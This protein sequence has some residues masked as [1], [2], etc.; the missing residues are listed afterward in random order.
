MVHM[1]TGVDKLVG[2]VARDKKVDINIAAKELN[3]DPAV[4][5]EWAEFL[6]EEGI[7]S[8][9][10][11]LSKTFILEK[12]LSKTEVVK[13]NKEYDNKKE[14]FVR[15]VEFALKKLEDE[16][17]GFES[18]KKQYD[19]MKHHIGDEID[20]VREEMEQLH[21]YEE[22][23]KNI[24]SD[25]LKQKVEYQKTLD[26]VHQRI[27]QEERRYKKIVEEVS[28]EA[29]KIEQERS[30]FLD[31]KKEEHDLLK[32]IEALKDIVK[33]VQ[34]RVETHESV[35]SNHE[36]RLGTLRELADKLRSDI[37]EK[38]KKEIEPLLKISDDQSGRI[39]RIQNE[40]VEKV[41]AGRDKMQEFEKQSREISER[42]ESFFK[43]R[44]QTEQV[45][46][47]L[48]KAKLEM[49]EELSAL[50]R[51]AKAFEITDK[52]ADT[53]THVRELEKKF[54]DFDKK[55]N[56]FARQLDYLKEVILGKNVKLPPRIPEA[57][58][59]AVRAKPKKKKKR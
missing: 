7:V 26:E 47:D 50:I 59:P 31:L 28:D 24:D 35:L 15:R 58:K 36:Q 40:I 20:A 25:I 23:K 4:V 8:L 42:F 14:A 44:S 56:G 51:K 57:K 9:Q 10:F 49:K 37:I 11:S 18:I 1:E 46:Q 48:E 16:T 41:K 29:H 45:M 2:I 3:V 34:T 43:R 13:K 27:G 38:R 6:E 12:Q 22:L 39:L 19:A 21:H 55:R 32:R 54:Q 53:N 5:Q 17:A 33:R 52:N 30:E